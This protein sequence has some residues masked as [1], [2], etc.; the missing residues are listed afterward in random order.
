MEAGTGSPVVIRITRLKLRKRSFVCV[1][2]GGGGVGGGGGGGTKPR[3]KTRRPCVVGP[4][5]A[6]LGVSFSSDYL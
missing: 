3:N 2:L 4:T 6:Q 5:V 1:F